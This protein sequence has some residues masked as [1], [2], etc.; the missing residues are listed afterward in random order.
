MNMIDSY[1]MTTHMQSTYKLT[2][3]GSAALIDPF[4]YK[5]N[6][7]LQV[8]P[9]FWSY[10]EVLGGLKNLGYSKVESLWYYDVMD[11]NELI[12]LKY[13]DGTKRMKIIALINGNVHLYVMHPVYGKEQI[14][15]L[16]NSLGPNGD[17]FD[18]GGATSVEDTTAVDQENSFEN[19]NLN[20]TTEGIDQK[21]SCQDVSLEGGTVSE[22]AIMDITLEETTDYMLSVAA[23]EPSP[24]P[25]T[26]PTPT[27]AA[28]QPTPNATTVTH[29]TLTAALSQLSLPATSSHPSLAAASSQ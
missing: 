11:D 17:K 24:T 8:D 3:I 5:S 4:L 19:V 21:D 29:P 27:V 22:D 2:K 25:A 6:E 28:T 13:D 12:L 10:F 14:L 23:T 15:S 9:D 26:Q 20:E 18:E 16:E 7:V 1:P